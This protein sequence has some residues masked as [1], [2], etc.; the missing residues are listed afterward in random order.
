MQ[1]STV[2]VQKSKDVYTARMQELEKIRKDNGSTKDLEKAESKVK[3][4]HDDYK[5]LVE[6]HNPVKTEFE[7]RMG[8]TCKVSNFFCLFIF[9]F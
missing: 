6:K 1:T 9:F 3:K 8:V 2:A 4:S 5:A 7:R